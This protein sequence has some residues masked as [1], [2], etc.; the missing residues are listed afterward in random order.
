MRW[1]KPL[2]IALTVTLPT[3]GFCAWLKARRCGSCKISVITPTGRREEDT[4]FPLF[5]EVAEKLRRG[6]NVPLPNAGDPL[7]KELLLKTVY[8]DQKTFLQA[9]AESLELQTCRDFEW[10]IVDGHADERRKY[11]EGRYS[12]PIK[13]IREKPSIW[14]GLKEPPG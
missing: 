10:I 5:Q 6:V 7:F 9:T 13:H 12:F 14:H 11:T 3:V 4:Y 2:Y 8:P 1:A